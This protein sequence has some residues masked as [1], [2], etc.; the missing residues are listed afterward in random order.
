MVYYLIKLIF[1]AIIIVIISELSKKSSFLGGLFASI[2]LISFFA[3]FWI[4]FDTKDIYKIVNLSYSIFWLVIPSLGLFLILPGLLKYGLNF[5]SSIFIAIILTMFLY[6]I[7][8]II[9]S[10]FGIKL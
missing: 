2:P 6:W 7:M 1:S 9:L 3:L 10:Y 5:Y 8:L 4:Y